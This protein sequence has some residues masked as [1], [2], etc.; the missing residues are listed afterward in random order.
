LVLTA[1]PSAAAAFAS[2]ATSPL[3]ACDPILFSVNLFKANEK[4]KRKSRFE[5]NPKTRSNYASTGEM[6]KRKR[7]T[8]CLM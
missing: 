2:A 3:E 5:V 4:E 6:M 1:A 7:V 8:R